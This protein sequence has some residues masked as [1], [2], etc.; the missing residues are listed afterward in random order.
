MTMLEKMAAAIGDQQWE[1]DSIVLA[2][3]A[4]IAIREPSEAMET[5]AKYDEYAWAGRNFTAMI[6]AIL[7]GKA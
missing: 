1:G 6:D 5:V 3:N 7:E 2:R 4:L